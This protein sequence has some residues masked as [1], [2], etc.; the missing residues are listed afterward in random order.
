MKLI[1]CADL[2]L[3]SSMTTHL[4][5]EKA[6]ERKAELLASFNRM[7]EYADRENVSAVLIAGDLFDRKNISATARNAVYH[8]ISTRPEMTFYYLKGNHDVRL[9][10]PNG[11][12]CPENL[13]LFGE[14]WTA[15]VQ[16]DER[17]R[18]VISG[19]E[20]CEENH[21]LIAN[22]LTLNREDVNIVMLHGQ[23][24]EYAA[25]DKAEVVPLRDL[26]GKGID[27]LA[28]GHVHGYKKETLDSRGE[29]CYPGCL[30]CRGFDEYGE[31]GFVLL[32]V[33]LEEKTVASEFIPFALRNGHYV[34]VDVSDC[35]S[36]AE[37]M[38]AINETAKK[39][40][41]PHEDF[42]K[43]VL[44]GEM[45][46]A[47]EKDLDYL[48]QW[49]QDDY[50]T[51]KVTDKTKIRIDYEDYRNDASLRGEFVRLVQADEVLSDEEKAQMIQYGIRALEGEEIE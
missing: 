16:T 4:T 11:K 43:F 30:E 19:V 42:V 49:I 24:A 33:D 27:Y 35:M 21:A 28:L 25:Q 31:H 12:E 9:F 7:M 29:Y 18:L 34:E 20:L 17:C 36:T 5:K 37:I 46:L 13:K 50:Y 45:A 44:V 38:D 6:K 26:R 23:E 14:E 39:E 3:D 1:H 8:A 10:L 47:S 51:V 22:S 2:H 32:D 15:Y 41:L 40:H 48:N